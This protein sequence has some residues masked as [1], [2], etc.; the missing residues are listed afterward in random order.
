M[1][2]RHLDRHIQAVDEGGD[3]LEGDRTGLAVADLGAD[4]NQAGRSLAH[5]RRDRLGH[6]RPSLMSTV[7]VQIVFEPDMAGYSA[8]SMITYLGVRASAEDHV[9]HMA[10]AAWL[11]QHQLPEVG[12][13]RHRWLRFSS[14]VSP[15]TSWTPPRSP[16][17]LAA[18]MDLDRLDGLIQPHR[19]AAYM[20]GPL[21]ARRAQR[22]PRRSWSSIAARPE[23]PMNMLR[24]RAVAHEYL[25]EPTLDP[26]DLRVNLRE[27][28]MLNRLPGGVADSVRAVSGALDGPGHPSVLDIGAVRRLRPPAA[29]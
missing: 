26:E 4:A 21:P 22:G 17:R 3:I 14:M 7:A 15:G 20:P 25:D 11:A 5:Q 10:E 6:R 18:G 16:G 2:T 9:A 29:A 12:H 8:C 13:L 28:A 1:P 19:D 27:M 24:A 23:V